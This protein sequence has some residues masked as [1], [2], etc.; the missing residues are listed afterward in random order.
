MDPPSW[1][2]PFCA[3]LGESGRLSRRSRKNQRER[4]PRPG[5]ALRDDGAPVRLREQPCDEEPQTETP[6]VTER[7]PAREAFEEP[8]QDLLFHSDA[9]IGDHHSHGVLA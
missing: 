3:R 5:L 8:P 9:A 4:R 6:V 7:Y 1:S 2:H